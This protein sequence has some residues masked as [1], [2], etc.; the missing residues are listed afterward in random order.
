MY[1]KADSRNRSHFSRRRLFTASAALFGSAAAGRAFADGLAD[2]PPREVGAPL[3]GHSERSK[4]VHLSRI[5]EAGPGVRNV[6]PFDAINS[7]TPLQKLLGAITPTDLHYERSH[8]GVPD[9]DPAEHRLLIHG[10]V[11]KPLVLTADDLM[12]MPSV[13]RVFHRMYRK[14]VGELEESR[15][16][17]HRAEHPWTCQHQR[18]DGRSAQVPDRSRQQGSRVDVDASG[19]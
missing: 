11:K 2:V 3:S 1:E 8:S 19:R 12:A 17:P 14:R 9:L 5:P 15:R 4:Y 18:M 6:D 7:K 13:S 16:D 10:L